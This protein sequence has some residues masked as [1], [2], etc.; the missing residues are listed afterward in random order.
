MDEDCEFKVFL[1]GL[2]AIT[3]IRVLLFW[4]VWFLQRETE[5]ISFDKT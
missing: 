2:E 3:M 1:G 4:V 5:P